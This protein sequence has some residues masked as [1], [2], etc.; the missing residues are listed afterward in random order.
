M[1]NLSQLQLDNP[2]WQFSLQQWNNKVLQEQLLALQNEQDYR[3]NL[4]LLAIWLSF[5]H[6]DIRPHLAELIK[7]SSE[8]HEQIVA[9]IRQ[10]RQAIP[11]E[12]PKQSQSLKAQLQA[13]ELQAEQIEQALLYQAC[14]AIPLER[15]EK[16]DSLDWLILNLRASD[17][18]KS[19]LSLLIQ[20]CLPMYPAQRIIER[21]Q[22]I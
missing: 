8:W 6:K 2:F 13:C 9:P 22:A 4:L 12:L 18:P 15:V 19:D 16:R 17:L 7:Q 3:I 10:V 20:N 14:D 1:N 5:E 11:S 21:L